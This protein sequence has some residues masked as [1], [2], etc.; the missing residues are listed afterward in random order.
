MK[1]S[2]Y[3]LLLSVFVYAASFLQGQ[4]TTVD[5]VVAIVGD[6]VVLLSEIE[7]QYQQMQTQSPDLVIDP[8]EK[9]SI[10]QSG[11]AHCIYP[12]ISGLS[13]L[14]ALTISLFRSGKTSV[15]NS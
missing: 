3:I 1:S 10:F 13:S 15:V 9:C 14:Q 11:T 4:T 12:V 7:A 2:K 6:N 5:K 8:S